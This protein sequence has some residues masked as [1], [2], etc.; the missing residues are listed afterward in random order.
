MPVRTIL[1]LTTDPLSLTPKRF[2]AARLRLYRFEVK[3]NIHD[4]P[5]TRRSL[6]LR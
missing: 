4:A 6:K 5:M 2:D 1:I 3:P